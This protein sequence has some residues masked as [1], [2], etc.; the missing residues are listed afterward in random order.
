MAFCRKVEHGFYGYLSADF[1]GI[2]MTSDTKHA[3]ADT[4]VARNLIMPGKKKC[5]CMAYQFDYMIMQLTW[6]G[7]KKKQN[8]I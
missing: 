1:G 4:F 5:T 3:S 6:I 2:N 7:K 8:K